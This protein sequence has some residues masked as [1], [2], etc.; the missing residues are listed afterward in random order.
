MS[1]CQDNHKYMYITTKDWFR[2]ASLA[3]GSMA[4]T[5]KKDKTE[6]KEEHEES[7]GNKEDRE[8]AYEVLAT[9]VNPIASPLAARKLTKRLYKT[10]KKASKEKNIRKGI[11][12]VQKFI[13]KGER[14]IVLIAGDTTPIEVYCHLPLVCE[15]AKIPYCYVPA[16]QDLGEAAGSKRP[17]CCV[18][19]KPNESY[20]SSY[21]ECL[22]DVTTLPRPI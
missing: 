17:T 10:V 4:K 21:D 15:D 11:R 12:D 14:G 1:G 7:G 6:E 5:P 3:V 8:R 16:K 9:R 18:L 19:L 22:T 2:P 13:K 20:Q